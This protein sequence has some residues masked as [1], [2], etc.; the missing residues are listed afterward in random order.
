[1]ICCVP[2]LLAIKRC[3][4]F[5]ARHIP[6]LLAASGIQRTPHLLHH[7]LQTAQPHPG[8]A[9]LSA[10]AHHPHREELVCITAFLFGINLLSFGLL[11]FHIF[12]SSQEI[13][14]HITLD[15]RCKMDI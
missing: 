14:K 11:L 4:M 7:S 1:M 13:K 12:S 8:H 5:S 3:P 2:L 9:S 15:W 6:A 10:V